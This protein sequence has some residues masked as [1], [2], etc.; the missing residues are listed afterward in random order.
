MSDV[1]LRELIDTEF[2]V[3]FGLKLQGQFFTAGF[4]D[5]TMRE[6]MHLVGYDILKQVLVMGDHQERTIL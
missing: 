4:L 2:G 1:A 3:A 6:Y 5:L